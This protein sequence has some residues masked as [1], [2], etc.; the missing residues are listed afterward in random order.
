[1][2]KNSLSI[3]SGGCFFALGDIISEEIIN[4]YF[5]DS[6]IPIKLG[7][8]LLKREAL[9]KA[10]NLFFSVVYMSKDS[11]ETYYAVLKSSDNQITITCFLHP[12]NKVMKIGTIY[13]ADF[14]K[15][16]ESWK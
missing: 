3:F 4:A 5:S 2:E 15:L 1:M 11:D 13:K 9:D 12:S 7:V 6:L 10:K 16:L 14:K 8:G